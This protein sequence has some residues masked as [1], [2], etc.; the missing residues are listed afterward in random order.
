MSPPR[1]RDGGPPLSGLPCFAQARPSSSCAC[2]MAWTSPAPVSTPIASR[3]LNSL[4]AASIVPL[5][6][7]SAHLTRARTVNPSSRLARLFSPSMT[8][9]GSLGDALPGQGPRRAPRARRARR[10]LPG[11]C[12]ASINTGWVDEGRSVGQTAVARIAPASAPDGTCHLPGPGP[13]T[14]GRA[15][16]NDRS[17]RSPRLGLRPTTVA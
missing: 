16:S 15:H 10:G 2:A 13:R 6:S 7:S 4:L 11:E 9:L 12:Q 17:P 14:S 3:P 1:A 5:T 8:F